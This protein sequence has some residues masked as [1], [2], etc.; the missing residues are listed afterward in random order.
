VR[1]AFLIPALAA[2][3]AAGAAMANGGGHLWGSSW[4]VTAM[5]E[6]DVEPA[7]G[8][9][10]A[11]VD[12][13]IAGRSG[14]NQYGG[15]VTLSADRFAAGTVVATRMA[16]PGRGDE[17]ERRFLEALEQVSG[18]RMTE[19]G[20]LELTAEDAALIRAVAP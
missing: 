5:G 7:D 20:E 6:L 18:W 15:P 16:C 4:Q 10:I 9:T 12:G 14:C 11:F 17:V 13:R 3:L 19:D 8:V 2:G 1:M